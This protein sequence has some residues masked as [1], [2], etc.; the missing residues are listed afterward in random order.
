M[1]EQAQQLYTA[2]I[3][4]FVENDAAKA[5]A[6]D[7]MDS[8]LDALQ[9]QFV[10]AIFESHAAGRIDLQVAV[11]LAVVGPASTSGSAT[12]RSTSASACGSSSPGGC[13]STTAP[14]GSALR[15]DDTGEMPRVVTS[16]QDGDRHAVMT[17]RRRRTAVVSDPERDEAPPTDRPTA[18]RDRFVCGA[19]STACRSAWSLADR[20]RC[21]PWSRTS[22]AADYHGHA[23][24]LVNEAVERHLRRADRWC[25]QRT[26]RRVHRPAAN[27]LA[28][29]AMPL[30]DGGALVTDRRRQRA[31][32]PRCHAHR[33]R[34]EHQPRVEDAGRC[35]RGA[36]R[37]AGGRSTI[38]PPPDDSPSKMVGEAHRVGAHDRRSAGAVAHRAGRSGRDG[39]RVRRSGHRRGRRA[40]PGGR[41]AALA[42]PS[43]S[44]TASGD[45]HVVGSHRQLVSAVANLL[46]NAVKYS[47]TGSSGRR[48]SRTATT[49]ASRSSSRHRRR[50]SRSRHRPNL[51]ALLSR[52]PCPQ[53]RHRRHRARPVD[54][55]SRRHQ[56]LAAR[57]PCNR[58]RAKGRCSP[59]VCQQGQS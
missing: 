7:D 33:L 31:R 26:E 24:V 56:P 11:Q 19:R 25:R 6:I 1:G 14:S 21:R 29:H 42:S 27:G 8:Y 36:G 28:V 18:S 16:P 34:G 43:T 3:E 49:A 57:S 30:E 23:A 59:C 39:R 44:T 45:L 41:R 20:A 51:R 10:Q 9:K 50:H 13:P 54:R 46:E 38:R 4:S 15:A 22:P 48:S 40:R 53:P 47:D 58:T 32:P 12:T 35:A 37:G 5:A 2:A 55:A 17:L 52:R